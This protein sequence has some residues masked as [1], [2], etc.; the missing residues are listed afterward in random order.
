MN[1]KVLNEIFARYIER[2]EYTN[3]KDHAEYY[4]WQVCYEYPKLMQNALAADE[5]SF[6]KELNKVKKCTFNIIDSYTQPFA[7]L[8]ELAKKEP[9]TVKQMFIDLYSDDH[10]NL[11]IQ[12]KKISDFFNRS[13]KLLKECSLSGYLYKQNSHSVSSYL[14][15]NDPDNHY[16]YKAVQSRRFADCIDFYDDWGSGDCIKLD[17]YNRMCDE[18]VSEIKN[19]EELLKCAGRRFDGSLKMEGGKLHPDTEFHILAFDIIYCST[20]YDLYDGVNYVKR[21]SK[22]KIAYQI[23]KAE[24]DTALE[25][26]SKARKDAEAYKNAVSCFTAMI[27]AGDVITHKK[28]GN[29]KVE[30]IDPDYITATF[31]KNTAKISLPVGIANGILTVDK[32]EFA[33]SVKKYS[34]ILKKYDSIKKN[35][36]YTGRMLEKYEEYIG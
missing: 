13:N 7:G 17:V 9:A 33:D 30:S 20:V 18:L 12:M 27:Q 32:P 36:E 25:A 4:K 31:A 28:Y 26:Y 2:F 16:M 19:N 23:E 11:S 5:N 21:D 15:L 24:A 10:G 14:F 35:L 3:G 8:V 34:G 29:G 1:K 6:S 22:E